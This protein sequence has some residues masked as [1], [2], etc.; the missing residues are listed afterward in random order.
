MYIRQKDTNII[1]VN[2][3]ETPLT[4]EQVQAHASIANHP[5][6]FEMVNEALPEKYDRLVY[7]DF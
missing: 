6:L 4:D 2:E 5:E 1:V 7:V 3:D